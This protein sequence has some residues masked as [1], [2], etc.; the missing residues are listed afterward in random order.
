MK[1]NE[2]FS[3]VWVGAFGCFQY[4]SSAL[5]QPAVGPMV[6]PGPDD[7]CRRPSDVYLKYICL[8]LAHQRFL[9]IT[10]LYKFAY[11]LL[12]YLLSGRKPRHIQG[13][14]NNTGYS[15]KQPLKCR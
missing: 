8:H 3:L 7:Q 11:F 9:T 2:Q 13:E 5:F 1:P 4:F 14:L 15:A 10:A 12:T 6:H